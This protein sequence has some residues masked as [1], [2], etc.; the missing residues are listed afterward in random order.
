MG[1]NNDVM[2]YIPS[3]KILQKGKKGSYEGARALIY[4]NRLDSVWDLGIGFTILS[5][6]GKLA[7]KTDLTKIQSSI[8]KKMKLIGEL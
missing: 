1:S 5:E 6:M 7:E 4:F 3:S 8:N 2:A